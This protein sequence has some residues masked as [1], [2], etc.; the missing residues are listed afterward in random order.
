MN[1]AK[2]KTIAILKKVVHT[3][4]P[5]WGMVEKFSQPLSTLWTITIQPLDQ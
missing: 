4:N 5:T 1:V 2:A 3:S